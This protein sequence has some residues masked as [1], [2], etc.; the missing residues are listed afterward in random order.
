MLI[1]WAVNIEKFFDEIESSI[2]ETFYR[3]D[4]NK[5]ANFLSN[6]SMIVDHFNYNEKYSHMIHIL[7]D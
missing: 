1:A 6:H 7:L 3:Q 4:M 5:R 2:Y